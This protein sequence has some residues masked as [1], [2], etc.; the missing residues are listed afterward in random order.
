MC[1]I[2][3]CSVIG[4]SI[5]RGSTIPY[6]A[7]SLCSQSKVSHNGSVAVFVFPQQT[8]LGVEVSVEH[9]VAVEV[10]HT[11]SYVQSYVQ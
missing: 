2:L 4:V 1:Y 5:I 10:V 11:T 3:L 9:P 7:R 8:V 6:D